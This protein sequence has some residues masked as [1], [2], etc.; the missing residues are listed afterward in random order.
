MPRC[1]HKVMHRKRVTC[2]LHDSYF[3]STTFKHAIPKTAEVHIPMASY[4]KRS[5]GCGGVSISPRRIERKRV[6]KFRCSRKLVPSLPRV[7]F[8]GHRLLSPKSPGPY[9]RTILIPLLI[10]PTSHNHPSRK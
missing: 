2:E 10:A 7:R 6:K 1:R 9:I 5:Q 8:L 4:G 3:R